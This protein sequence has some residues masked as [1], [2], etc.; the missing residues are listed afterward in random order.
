MEVSKAPDA[1][2]REAA[3]LDFSTLLVSPATEC[4]A[5]SHELS[6]CK[7][8]LVQRL[9]KRCNNA[10][11]QEALVEIGIKC[12]PT[13]LFCTIP[14]I[15][16]VLR[17]AITLRGVRFVQGT[18]NVW[19]GWHFLEQGVGQFVRLL[20][21]AVEILHEF[22]HYLSQVRAARLPVTVLALM[23]SLD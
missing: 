13:K 15:E 9:L 22:E 14:C 1:A 2:P 4:G 7:G 16:L 12:A 17:V 23:R 21:R 11:K 3:F 8:H 6:K 18:A 10:C 20:A 5:A 19:R